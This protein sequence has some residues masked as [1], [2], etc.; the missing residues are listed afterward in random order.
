VL[1]AAGDVLYVLG[2]ARSGGLSSYNVATGALMASFSQDQQYAGLYRLPSG[3]LLAVA[4]AN[5]RLAFFS[6][7]LSPLGSM[8]TTLQVSDVF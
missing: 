8:D 6:P 4:A 3:T 5:P 1:S 2:A 7:S